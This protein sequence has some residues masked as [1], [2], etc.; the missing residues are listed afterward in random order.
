M[1]TF[2]H[3]TRCRKHLNIFPGVVNISNL[4]FLFDHQDTEMADRSHFALFQHRLDC[5]LERY[6]CLIHIFEKSYYELL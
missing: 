1:W 4:R 5:I 2:Q 3:T 6:L